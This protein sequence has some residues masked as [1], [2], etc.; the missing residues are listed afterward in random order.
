M[1]TTSR[2]GNG[3]AFSPEKD[4][5]MFADMARQGKHLNGVA[6]LGHGWRFT[7]GDPEDAVF[8][9]AY[10]SHPSADYFEIFRAAGWAPVISLGDTH[11]FKAA[12]GTTPVHSGVESR[13]DELTRNRSLYLRYSAI[14][15]IAFLLVTLGLRLVSW[16]EGVELVLLVLF[17]LPVVYTVTPLVG[18]WR[19]LNTL[20][21]SS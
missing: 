20:N 11:I 14:T 19:Q 4:L 12:P 10:E 7:D 2:M 13:R 17:M 21:R 18:Y 5:A 6:K 8:D 9:L 3:L 15:L 1:S 16:N